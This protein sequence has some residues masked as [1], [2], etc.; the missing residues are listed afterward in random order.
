MIMTMIYIQKCYIID[1]LYILLTYMMK[2][3]LEAPLTGAK[4]EKSKGGEKYCS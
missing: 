4:E 2:V 3:G 1:Y